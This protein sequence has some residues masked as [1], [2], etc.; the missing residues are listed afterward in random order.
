MIDKSLEEN[1]K[2]IEE[3][4]EELD[5]NKDN[6]DKSIKIYEEANGIYKKLKESLDD[7]K[8]KIEIIGK[9]E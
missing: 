8:A 9:D 6:L 1:F 2:K 4:L 5:D 7:Y 3:L